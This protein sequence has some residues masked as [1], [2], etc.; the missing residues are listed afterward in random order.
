MTVTVS[1]GI[2][3]GQGG[4]IDHLVLSPLLAAALVA[5]SYRVHVRDDLGDRASDHRVVSV[6]S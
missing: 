3:H 1:A 6:L 4:W 2:D 5:G